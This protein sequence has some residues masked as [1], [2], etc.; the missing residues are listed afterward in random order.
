MSLGLGP[1]LWSGRI[2]GVT[3]RVHPWPLCGATYIGT[4]SLR[5]L[6]WRLWLAV[7]AGPPLAIAAMHFQD[8]DFVS[9]RDVSRS[10]LEYQPANPW[11]TIMLTAS[12]INLGEYEA[13]RATL[14]RIGDLPLTEAP[15]ARAAIAN[16]LA[17]TLLL[18]ESTMRSEESKVRATSYLE[19]PTQC[20]RARSAIAR[21]V[22][23]C[24]QQPI[25]RMKPWLSLTMQTTTR[26][27]LTIAAIA[28]A[29][30][31]SRSV[32]SVVRSKRNRLLPNV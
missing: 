31:H 3:V 11:L 21:R 12:Q 23:W 15:V 8:A 17:L 18:S 20:I 25:D 9:A 26:L 16:N 6:R 2:F 22:P 29:G 7:L 32:N 13:A 28:R 27:S 10:A 4:N 5:S 1:K 14:E 24:W 19:A 30:A